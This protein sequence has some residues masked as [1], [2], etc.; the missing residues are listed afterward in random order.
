MIKM[1]LRSTLLLSSAL[2]MMT[3]AYGQMHVSS[4]TTRYVLLEEGTGSWC[5]YCPDGAEDI[6]GSLEPS[7]PHLLVASFHNADPMALTPDVFNTDYIS[8]VGWPGATIDRNSFS[9]SVPQ[10]RPWESYVATDYTTTPNF[11][12]GMTCTYDTGSRLLTVYVGATALTS[13]LTG[14][15]NLNAYLVEDSI[16]SAGGNSQ[17]NYAGCASC[18]S[19]NYTYSAMP[20]GTDTS[21]FYGLGDPIAP[22]SK[23]WHMNVVRRILSNDSSIYGDPVA[24]FVN[25]ALGDSASLKYT[26]TVPASYVPRHMRVIGFVELQGTAGTATTIENSVASK[27]RLMPLNML[28]VAQTPTMMDVELFP[29]PAK[30]YVNVRGMLDNPTDTRIVIYNSLGQV[31]ADKQYK[32]SGS[33][34]SENIRLDDCANGLYFMNIINNG[35]S[36]SKQFVINR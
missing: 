13:G 5:G 15:W 4:G 3:H 29:N 21:W 26:Y 23:Y 32:A 36:I 17:A 35:Q 8:S 9:G 34:F 6:E 18:G 7:Y 11:S 20:P 30:N 2:L 16:S 25:P 14:S 12:V 22:S 27:M 31:V 33:M 24:A 1:K 10:G 19:H 28:S